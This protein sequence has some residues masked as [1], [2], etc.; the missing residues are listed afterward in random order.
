MSLRLA[1]T[2]WADPSG[3]VHP[4]PYSKHTLRLT[5]EVQ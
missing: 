1:R 3:E 2:A 4:S 5:D